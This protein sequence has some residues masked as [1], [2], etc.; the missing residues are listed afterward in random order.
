MRREAAGGGSTVSE[1]AF[2]SNVK[3][4]LHGWDAVRV[5]TGDKDGIPDVNHKHGWIE[6]KV[7]EW[8][9]RPDT[10]VDFGHYT[11]QQRVW[12][13]RRTRAGGRVHLLVR[14]GTDV[15]LLRGD[16][17]AMVCGTA[18][19]EELIAAASRH[20]KPRQKWKKELKDAILEDDFERRQRDLFDSR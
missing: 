4:A 9:A 20:W 5:E 2:W 3:P 14:I 16:V 12:H 18:N 6:L 1:A 7:T 10:P 8:P 13:K 19:R 15:L 17:A 11:Q